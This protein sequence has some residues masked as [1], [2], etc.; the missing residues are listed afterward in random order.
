MKTI[1]LPVRDFALPVPRRGSIDLH[2]GYNLLNQGQEI[3]EKVQKQRQQED[4]YYR[5]EVKVSRTFTRDAYRFAVSGRIDGIF[6]RCPPLIEEIKSTVNIHQLKARLE[7]MGDHPYILQ[8]QTYAYFYYL[9]HGVLPQVRLSLVSSSNLS[10]SENLAI[11]LDLEQYEKWLHL[12]LSELVA[13]VQA[14]EA[15]VMRRIEIASAME[16]PFSQPRSGQIELMQAVETAVAAGRPL[17]VQAATGLGKTMAIMFPALKDALSR[18]Q[19]LVYVTPKN[20]Q[21]PV[22]E[23]ALARLQSAGHELRFLTLTAKGKICCLSE[24]VCTPEHCQY[25]RDYYQK[26]YE[27]KLV[28]TMAATPR[29]NFEVFRELA[30]RYKVCPFELSVDAVARADVVVGDYNYVFSPRSLLG[31]LTSLNELLCE[32]PNLVIDE[33]HNLPDRACDYYS[34][35]I[36]TA[37]FEEA[38]DL[39]RTLSPGLSLEAQAVISRSLEIIKGQADMGRKEAQIVLKAEPFKDAD[40]AWRELLSRYLQSG[41]QPAH[42][43]A[44]IRAANS[45]SDFTEGLD[46]DAEHFFVTSRRAHDAVEL[47]ITCCD[48]SS[49]LHDTYDKFSSAVGFSATLKPFEYY[50]RLSGF[51]LEKT[52]FMECSSPFP[53][54]NR[55]ILVIPQVSTKYSDRA[56]NYDKISDAIRR[57]VACRPGNYFA[58]FPSFEFL[59]EVASRT[60]AAEFEI[61]CQR[62]DMKADQVLLWIDRLKKPDGQNRPTLIFAVQ[63]GVFSEGVDYPGEALIGALIVGPALPKFNLERE[64][65]RAYYEKHYKSG[66]DYAYT[67]PAMT[68]VVQAAGRVIRSENDRGLIVLMD[69]RFMLKSYASAM[70]GDWFSRSVSELVSTS[71]L[72][73]ISEFWGSQPAQLTLNCLSGNS[74]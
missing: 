25:A 74:P 60:R 68:R 52:G 46:F 51:D 41:Q 47:K 5:S 49:F 27:N 63:G 17:M 57:I 55:K 11:P 13:D 72:K 45:W 69:Q 19:K 28:E 18:G 9:Q 4:P 29:L 61:L 50:T 6:D 38:F 65:L 71:I 64:L 8:A 21:H 3:H 7:L 67:Y 15:D 39:A 48:A 32:K 36:S 26:V 14:I 62:A 22:A 58:F 73:D 42:K 66:F 31:R 12:R 24:P 2:S 43:D 54:Q 56:R 70:P 23:D 30:D 33:A 44:I 59:G 20:S 34:P 40:R 35:A 53:P 37:A 10:L 16:F 1:Q